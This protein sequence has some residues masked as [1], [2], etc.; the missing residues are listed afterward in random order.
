MESIQY[1]KTNL[2]INITEVEADF[3]ET[4]LKETKS[5]QIQQLLTEQIEKL[6]EEKGFNRIGLN[7]DIVIEKLTSQVEKLKSGAAKS[8]ESLKECKI[9]AVTMMDNM[10]EERG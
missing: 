2:E 8:E 3:K 10:K 6:K 1:E 9:W 5:K 7:K 4:I